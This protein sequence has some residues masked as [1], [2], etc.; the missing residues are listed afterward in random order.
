MPG[1]V[2]RVSRT[3]VFRPCRRLWYLHDIQHSALGHEQRSDGPL[4]SERHVAGLH[5]VAVVHENLHL[6]VGVN[7][8]EY[9]AGNLHTA[10]YTFFFYE[11]AALASGIGRDCGEGR[12]VAVAHIFGESEV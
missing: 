4:R 7:F 12:M 6:E 8:S 2:L 5:S 10:Q 1:V 9:F 11:Q 3:R